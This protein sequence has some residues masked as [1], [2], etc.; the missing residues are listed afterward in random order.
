[1]GGAAGGAAGGPARC[2]RRAGPRVAAAPRPSSAGAPRAG[3]R[4]SAAAAVQRAS[5]GRRASDARGPGQRVGGGAGRGVEFPR[6]GARGGAGAGAGR[7]PSPQAPPRGRDRP[8]ARGRASAP[9]R[10]QTHR[11][12][13][14]RRA[15]VRVRAGGGRCRC[16]RRANGAAC[17]ARVGA[18][19]RA[20]TPERARGA[21]AG[22]KISTQSL[23]RRPP[24]G[25]G[26][27][28]TERSWRSAPRPAPGC[29]PDLDVG[30]DMPC[31]VL[32]AI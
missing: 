9:R 28:F 7:R 8:G 26:P 32:G 14:G 5:A 1:M 21:L 29:G 25:A 11:C 31:V 16:G 18:L 19:V 30:R 20:T 27:T 15:W 24:L 4:A 2:G 23:T 13:R 3:A 12:T 22:G 6:R 10:K 17:G